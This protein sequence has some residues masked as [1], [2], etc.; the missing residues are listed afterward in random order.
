MVK[1][2]III[3]LPK[4]GRIPPP[5]PPSYA[6]GCGKKTD[7][8]LDLFWGDKGVKIRAFRLLG[9]M[10]KYEITLIIENLVII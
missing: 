5:L 7:V 2:M 3:Y 4:D 10:N 8:T 1:R 9:K 6:Y